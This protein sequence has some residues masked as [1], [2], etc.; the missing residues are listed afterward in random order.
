MASEVTLNYRFATGSDLD[1][2]A[3]WN[4]QLTGDEGH[5]N[6]MTVLQLRDRMQ[7]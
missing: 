3:R 4:H 7:G 5:R 1:L 2:L 6:R